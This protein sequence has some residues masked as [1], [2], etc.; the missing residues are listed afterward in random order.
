MLN[1]IIAKRLNQQANNEFRSSYL[2]LDI[3]NY[4][5]SVG[6]C[7]FGSWFEIQF[8]EELEHARLFIT[9]LLE[10]NEEIEFD[11]RPMEIGNNFCDFI[12]P[13]EVSMMNERNNNLLINEIYNLAKEIND[14]NTAL[15]ITDFVDKHLIRNDCIRTFIK[16]FNDCNYNKV[17]KV[18]KKT[19]LES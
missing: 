4:Y 1:E 3:S 19:T 2:C 16:K 10:H 8:Q 6:L 7:A 14:Y 15:F 13:M 11:D 5:K 17:K 9:Y 18:I 12:K